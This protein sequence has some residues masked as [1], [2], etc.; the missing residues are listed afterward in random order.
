MRP[1]P[2]QAAALALPR[3][4]ARAAQRTTYVPCGALSTFPRSKFHAL[5]PVF[6]REKSPS[7]N[8]NSHLSPPLSISTKLTCIFIASFSR[9]GRPWAFLAPLQADSLELRWLVDCR[10]SVVDGRFSG[11]KGL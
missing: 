8:P 5:L 9:L 1:A 10:L 11:I 6:S 7:I 4:V 2:E 3:L